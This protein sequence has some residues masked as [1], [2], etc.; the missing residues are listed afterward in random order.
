M[1]TDD[2]ETEL[3]AYIRRTIGSAAEKEDDYDWSEPWLHPPGEMPVSVNDLRRAEGR[4]ERKLHGLEE[5]LR[6]K[7]NLTT[8][9]ALFAALRGT[10]I[11]AATW[12]SFLMFVFWI[13]K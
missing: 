5:R 6:E 2:R 4:M 8:T 1:A 3:E 7:P 13:W 11:G 9:T 10:I 12:L